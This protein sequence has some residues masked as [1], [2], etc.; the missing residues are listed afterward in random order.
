M[1]MRTP[2]QWLD[3][4][5][6]AW[7]DVCGEHPVLTKEIIAAIQADARAEAESERDKALAANKL[8]VE[9]LEKIDSIA[10]DT[11]KFCALSTEMQQMQDVAKRMIA[12]VKQP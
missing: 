5:D 6:P 2:E 7:Q 10:T 1:T 3:E 11:A 9:A 8:L 4:N 12:A